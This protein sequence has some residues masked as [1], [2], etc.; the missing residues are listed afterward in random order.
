M[1]TPFEPGS[2]PPPATSSPARTGRSGLDEQL[3]MAAI[4]QRYYFDQRTKVQIGEELGISRFKVSR[5][6]DV[7]TETGLVRIE[8]VLPDAVDADLSVRLR[9]GFDLRRAI[10]AVPHVA[11]AASMRDTLGRAAASLLGD[12]VGPE[13]VLGVTSG[14]TIDA[15]ARHLT[16]LAGCEVIQLAGM[17]GDLDDNPVDV[18]RRVAELSGGRARS[19]YAPLMVATAEAAEALKAHPTIAETFARFPDVT[20]AL[21]AIGSIQPPE[22]R[23]Y[24]ALTPAQR[25]QLI[26]SGAVADIAGAVLDAA[27]QPVHDVDDRLL[28]IGV[29]ELRAIDEVVVVGGGA[30]KS[31]AVLA[32]LRSGLVTTLVTDDAVARSL[33]SEQR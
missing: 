2:A 23:L 18:L 14:R 31:A 16:G 1:S 29:E 33:L 22:S 3:L 24:D 5:L 11:G 12:I 32:A 19:I 26:D 27:G 20:I 21:T 17:S 28:G 30:R 8:I 6:L 15:V 13:D 9:E 10:V 4:A 7:A 25:T